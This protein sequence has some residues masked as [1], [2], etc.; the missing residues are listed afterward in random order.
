[1]AEHENISVKTRY[2]EALF[3]PCEL[4]P[5]NKVTVSDIL[6]ET[7]TARQTFYNN[8]RDINDLISYVF[9]YHF[10]KNLDVFNT[11]EGSLKSLE[12]A[13]E[14]RA[15]FSQ[16]PHHTGQNCYRDTH[17][18]TLKRGYYKLVFQTEEPPED[19]PRKAFIDAYVYG[20]TDIFLEWCASNMTS[21]P[22]EVVVDVYYGTR[23]DF[24]P[25]YVPLCTMTNEI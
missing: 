7:G 2:M 5:L 10:E 23:P 8:F 13:R 25:P 14:H 6:R 4:K 21:P 9:I 11:R 17:M 22:D 24:L 20:C 19:D 18:R 16:L 1:M 15:L 12:F 3:K